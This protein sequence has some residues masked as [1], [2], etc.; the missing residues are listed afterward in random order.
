MI[1]KRKTLNAE[2]LPKAGCV[3]TLHK[4]VVLVC[5]AFI[6]LSKTLTC[7]VSKHQWMTVKTLPVT[8][9]LLPFYD[10]YCTPHTPPPLVTLP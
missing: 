9:S 2:K 5:V 1:A 10:V 6:D 4:Q 3:R 7:Q 8:S